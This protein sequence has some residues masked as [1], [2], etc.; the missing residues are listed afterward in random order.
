MSSFPGFFFIHVILLTDPVC[1]SS[2]VVR[3]QEGTPCLECHMYSHCL[4]V[5]RCVEQGKEQESDSS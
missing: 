1:F 4:N 3:G 5:V 2:V